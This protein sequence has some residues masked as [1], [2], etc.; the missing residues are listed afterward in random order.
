MSCST[1]LEHFSSRYIQAYQ[2]VLDELPRYFPCGQ[3]SACIEGKYDL[4]SDEAVFG[5]R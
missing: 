1:S 3:G 5:K 2:D 4:E